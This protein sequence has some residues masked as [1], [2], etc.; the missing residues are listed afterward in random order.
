[1]NKQ[2][3]RTIM[4]Y[5]VTSQFSYCPL[6]WM[7]HSRRLNNEDNSVSTH[8][9][10][11]QVLSTEM[12]KIHRGLSPEILRETFVPKTSSYRND[13]NAEKILLK[14]VKCTLF[15]TVLNRYRF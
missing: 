3:R 13:R 10:N 9:R 8:H 5:F 15:I 14:N 12:F 4:N 11:L 2:K 6:I 7:F 1:M